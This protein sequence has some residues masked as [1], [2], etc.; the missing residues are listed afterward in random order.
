MPK[1]QHTYLKTRQE[2]KAQH[3]AK[4]DKATVSKARQRDLDEFYKALDSVS[5]GQLKSM[6]RDM[7]A[8]AT[9]LKKKEHM[10]EDDKTRDAVAK[11][12]KEV[13]KMLEKVRDYRNLQSELRKPAKDVIDIPRNPGGAD[14]LSAVIALY[15]VLEVLVRMVGREK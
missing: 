15:A 3:T 11:T 10:S 13:R 14:M 6:H 8:L 7:A 12:L 1:P 5:P 2:A 9:L 4:E